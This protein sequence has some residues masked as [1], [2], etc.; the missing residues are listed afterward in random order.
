MLYEVITELLV[1][2]DREFDPERRAEII[3][4]VDGILANEHHYV[5]G[6]YAPFER[7]AY[8]NKFG[9]PEGRNNFV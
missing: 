3:R 7:I 5:L 8:W 6:W 4:E 1:E 9:H 2:Y